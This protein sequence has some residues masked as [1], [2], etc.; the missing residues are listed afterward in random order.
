MQLQLRNAVDANTSSPLSGYSKLGTCMAPAE[1]NLL[2]QA[3]AWTRRERRPCGLQQSGRKLPGL[4]R[5]KTLTVM[6]RFCP[7]SPLPSA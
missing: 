3:Q 1:L 6:W 5:P 4:Q 2:P 7:S